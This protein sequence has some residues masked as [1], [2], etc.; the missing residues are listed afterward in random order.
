MSNLTL[1]RLENSRWRLITNEGKKCH[2]L[3]LLEAMKLTTEPQN[4]VDFYELLNKAEENK[5]VK[6]ITID[7]YIKWFGN[8][9]VLLP[10]HIWGSQ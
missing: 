10:N 2:G 9:T 8:F 1:R 5:E 3:V 4:I 7:R 6:N